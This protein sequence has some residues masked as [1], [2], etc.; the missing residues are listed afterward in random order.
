MSPRNRDI[1]CSVLTTLKYAHVQCAP[2]P[3]IFTYFP[4]KPN[5]FARRWRILRASTACAMLARMLVRASKE[6][7]RSGKV[8][9]RSQPQ[10]L[11][12]NRISS[13]RSWRTDKR[14]IMWHVVDGNSKWIWMLV[15]RLHQLCCGLGKWIHFARSLFTPIKRIFC[16]RT[17]F[18]TA[19][20]LGFRP[21]RHP[22]HHHV[23]DPTNT[24]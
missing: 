5:G 11:R 15:N 2:V 7:T 4:T 19:K 21:H 6:A 24:I 1:Y 12:H 16:C 8:A 18:K 23:C 22:H 9:G 17:A 14:S 13:S 10:R 20:T 3:I